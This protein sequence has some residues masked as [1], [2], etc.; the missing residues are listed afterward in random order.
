MPV[1]AFPPALRVVAQLLPLSHSTRLL[2]GIWTG[3]PWSA[4]VGDIAAL[5]A[6]FVVCVALSARAFRWE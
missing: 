1:A 2:Q 3:G 4:Y 5:A 6:V